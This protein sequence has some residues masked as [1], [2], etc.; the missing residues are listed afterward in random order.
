MG[1]TT[2]N[3]RWLPFEVESIMSPRDH[4][5]NHEGVYSQ[6]YALYRQGFQ[7]W[8]SQQEIQQLAAHVR[9]FETPRLESELVS[10]YFRIPSD[11][12]PGEFISV[13]RALQLV[14]GNIPQKLSPVYVGRAFGELGFQ[15]VKCRGVRGY[16]VVRRSAEELAALSRT[17]AYDAEPDGQ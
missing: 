17:M 15:R 4:P 16:R 11:C 3:R 12:E 8:F 13:A 10:Y 6:A 1:I 9:Q 7:Y 5:F 14:S 2:G